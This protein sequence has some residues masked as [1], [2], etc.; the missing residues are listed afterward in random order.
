MESN[1]LGNEDRTRVGTQTSDDE[2]WISEDGDVVSYSFTFVD[3]FFKTL[4]RG[5]GFRTA[6]CSKTCRVI[7]KRLEIITVPVA[8]IRYSPTNVDMI[9][10]EDTGS[11]QRFEDVA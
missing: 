10:D 1:I 9:V 11:R 4:F 8:P 5:G 6:C 2:P 7:D 3:E